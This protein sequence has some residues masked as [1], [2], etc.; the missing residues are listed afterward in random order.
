M[1]VEKWR[2]VPGH[3][4][5][6][7]VSSEGQVRTLLPRT[8]SRILKAQIRRDG[9]LEVGLRLPDGRRLSKTVHSLVML[10]FAGPCPDGHEIRHLD[11]DHLNNARTNLAYGTRSENAQDR[12]R[13]GTDASARKTHCPASHPYSPENTAVR[14]GKRECRECNRARNRRWRQEQQQVAS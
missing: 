7:D 2:P 11:G 3:E 4:W 6:Y 13:H 12:V 8:S 5:R 9:R 10:A 1:T 14:R